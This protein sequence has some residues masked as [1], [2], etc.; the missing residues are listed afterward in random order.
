[1]LK[2]IKQSD[3]TKKTIV[4]N[5]IFIVGVTIG[6]VLLYMIILDDRLYRFFLILSLVGI[7]YFINNK[8]NK[9]K[10]MFNT[11]EVPLGQEELDLDEHTR[12]YSKEVMDKEQKL[13]MIDL[14]RTYILE[15]LFTKAELDEAERNMYREKIKEKD[16]EMNSMLQELLNVKTKF[17]KYF[18][19]V[20]PMKE[21]AASLAPEKI[22]EGTIASL[23]DEIQG[24]IG[25]L[26]QETI[27][28][29]KNSNFVDEE[30]NLTRSGY[31]ALMKAASK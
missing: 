9:L 1:M 21:I 3:N 13:E 10:D 16:S 29:L 24:I 12:I 4:N 15:E 23:N 14:D 17:Q 19:K 26:S 30:F 27:E 5:A 31:K 11:A 28:A 2:R 18:I 6:V 22:T 7:A 20:D 8:L 25:S